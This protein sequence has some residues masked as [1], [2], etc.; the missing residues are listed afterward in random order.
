MKRF[1][2]VFLLWIWIL[3]LTAN[4]ETVLVPVG[5]LVGL[6]LRTARP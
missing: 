5:Q 3:P 4:A 6:Q 2:R 1:L